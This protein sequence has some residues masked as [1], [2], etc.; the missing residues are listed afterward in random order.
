MK[1]Q[2][3]AWIVLG[4]I[5]FCWGTLPISPFSYFAAMIREWGDFLFVRSFLPVTMQ[6]LLIY[7]LFTVL[8]VAFLLIG[9]SRSRIYIAGICALAGMAHHLVYC[10]RTDRLYEASLAL[11][12]GLALALLFLII[13]SPQPSLWLSEGYIMAL[14]VYILYDG[15]LH[16]LFKTADIGY[17]ALAPFMPVP[18]KSLLSSFDGLWG[19]PLFV[20]VFMPAVMVLIPLIFLS[21]GRQKR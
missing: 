8:F 16:P 15:L 11:A 6:S 1:S 4:I 14:P 20:W 10:L 2:T 21:K 19:I 17:R 13:R 18:Q 12:I 5:F 9:R 7:L 3:R